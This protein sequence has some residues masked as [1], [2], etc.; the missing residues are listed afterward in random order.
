MIVFSGELDGPCALAGSLI[1][2]RKQEFGVR[3]GAKAGG[4]LGFAAGPAP[5]VH[6]TLDALRTYLAESLVLLTR[7]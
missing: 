4:S 2:E 3:C 6:T 1:E 5:S 7:L